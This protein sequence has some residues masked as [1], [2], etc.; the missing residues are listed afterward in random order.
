MHILLSRE[1]CRRK[2]KASQKKLCRRSSECII[3]A[4]RMPLIYDIEGQDESL[5]NCVW[6]IRRGLRWRMKRW[7]ANPIIAAVKVVSE[8]REIGTTAVHTLRQTR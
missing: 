2:E 4:K 1:K 8:L 7:Y 3:F 6:I 5:Y